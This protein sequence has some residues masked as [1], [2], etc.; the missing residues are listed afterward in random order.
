[1]PNTITIDL[2]FGSGTSFDDAIDRV[3]IVLRYMELILGRP[4][5]VT[6]LAVE[7]IVAGGERAALEV[8]WSWAPR[9][10]AIGE[11][12]PA[13]PG[14]LLISAAG[15]PRE[16][17]RILRN[18]MRKSPERQLARQSFSRAFENQRSF[19]ADRLIGAAN[20]FDLLPARAVHVPTRPPKGFKGAKQ[21]SQALFR[22]LP[23]SLQR[24]AALHALGQ[25]ERPNLR[26]KIQ[27]RA[28]LILQQIGERFPDLELVIREAVSCRNF[29]VHGTPPRIDYGKELHHMQFF[30]DA[31]EFVFGAS[32]LVEAGLNLKTWA[33][34]GSIGAHPF[35]SFRVEYGPQLAELKR[36]LEKPKAALARLSVDGRRTHL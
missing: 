16:F 31:L 7:T 20:M 25:L 27:R 35:G 32:E 13:H 11:G 26:A 30:T 12:R 14:D 6:Q 8:Y 1:L 23:Q 2:D 3:L 5:F 33:Q 4:Q 22:A 9:R 29:L 19:H 34:Q 24:E 17:G 21:K 36:S 28:N 18:W 10:N 15:E